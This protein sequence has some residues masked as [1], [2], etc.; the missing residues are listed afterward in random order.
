MAADKGLEVKL[1]YDEL[2]SKRK[3]QKML[4][5]PPP[6]PEHKEMLDAAKPDYKPLQR[7]LINE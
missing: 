4:D 5:P 6:P 1:K 7:A 2:L 3:I